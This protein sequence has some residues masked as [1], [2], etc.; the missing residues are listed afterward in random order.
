MKMDPKWLRRESA[1]CVK[2]AQDTEKWQTFEESND[3]LGN[4]KGE[5][6]PDQLND[7]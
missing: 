4:V 7:Y 2:L 1:D 6:Y 3:I 5:K